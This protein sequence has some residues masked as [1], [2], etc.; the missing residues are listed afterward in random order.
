[1]STSWFSNT[2][3]DNTDISDTEVIGQQHPYNIDD[4]HNI[5]L[6]SAVITAVLTASVDY[7]TGHFNIFEV[8]EMI[9]G[10]I[11]IRDIQND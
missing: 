9:R 5:F 3:T 8:V 2:S 10:E 7:L 11:W 4:V 1:M 6:I